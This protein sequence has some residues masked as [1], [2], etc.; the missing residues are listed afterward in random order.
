MYPP[1]KI[2]FNRIID[3]LNINYDHKVISEI[4]RERFS[5]KKNVDNIINCIRNIENIKLIDL[6]KE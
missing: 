4:G 2:L 6:D 3:L 1:S 5:L